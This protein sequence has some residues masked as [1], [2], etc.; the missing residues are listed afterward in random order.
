M[1]RPR[2]ISIANQHPALRLDR[3]AVRRVI[4]TLDAVA[5]STKGTFREGVPGG[6]LSIVFMTDPALA[7]LHADFLDDPTPTDVITFEGTPELGTAGEICVSADRAAD[8]A[9][10]QGRD[11]SEELTLYLVHGWLHLA[12]Y[13][14]LQPALKRQMRAAEKRAM[15]ALADAGLRPRFSLT[16]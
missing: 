9:Q 5:A 15:R 16:A 12:G 8:Y 11:F 10:S 3:A 13:D 2:P 14:D 1:S 4:S 6:E 7:Q